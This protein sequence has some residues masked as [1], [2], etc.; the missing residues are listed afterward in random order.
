[1]TITILMM[2]TM[3]IYLQ[4]FVNS[5]DFEKKS[6]FKLMMLTGAYGRSERRIRYT[7]DRSSGKWQEHL[8]KCRNKGNFVRKSHMTENFISW[9]IIL[10][11]TSGLMKSRV[12]PVLQPFNLST[13]S[14]FCSASPQ[15]PREFPMYSAFAFLLHTTHKFTLRC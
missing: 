9:W 5:A 12:R 7:D 1:M 3:K 4:Q 11:H 6:F 15:P 2:T 13:N 8:A 10:P 14:S